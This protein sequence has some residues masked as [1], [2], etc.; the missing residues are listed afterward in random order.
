MA[1]NWDATECDPKAREGNELSMTKHFCFVLMDVGIPVL[2]EDNFEEAYERV[3]LSET[4]N[5]NWFT[6]RPLT[7]DDFKLRVGYRT[8]VSPLTRNQYEKKALKIYWEYRARLKRI[9]EQSNE[10]KLEVA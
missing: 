7:L 10:K 3:A 2:T 1:L 6:D 8:N 4:L 5:Q 9:V